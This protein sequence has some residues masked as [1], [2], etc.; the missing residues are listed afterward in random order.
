MLTTSPDE[1][2]QIASARAADVEAGRYGRDQAVEDVLASMHEAL[3]T[4]GIDRRDYLARVTG[5]LKS[6]LPANHSTL[7][8][9]PRAMF[10]RVLIECL[11]DI[12]A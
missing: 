10:Y 1:A 9:Q 7:A 6:R 5:G 4:P 12:K 2:L 3:E 11:S 8:R